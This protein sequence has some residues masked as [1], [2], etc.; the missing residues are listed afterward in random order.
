MDDE[1]LRPSLG[2]IESGVDLRVIEIRFDMLVSSAVAIVEHQHFRHGLEGAIGD[3]RREPVEIR[4]GR[5]P[6]VS[7]SLDLDGRDDRE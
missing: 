5:I 3:L 2:F 7:S 1:R 4:C 6:L